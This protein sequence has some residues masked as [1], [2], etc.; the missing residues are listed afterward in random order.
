MSYNTSNMTDVKLQKLVEKR[1]QQ[2]KLLVYN[3]EF[4][5]IIK[6][7]REKY[8][9]PIDG[10]E[11]PEEGLSMLREKVD[12]EELG[13]DMH[14]ILRKFDLPPDWNDAIKYFL[15]LNNISL[16]PTML[17]ITVQTVIPVDGSIPRELSIKIDRF[18]TL[19]DMIDLWPLIET[20]Q[21][22][23]STSELKKQQPTQNLNLYIRA[24]QLRNEGKTSNE[25][26]DILTNETGETIS[27]DD[28]NTYMHRFNQQSARY[29]DTKVG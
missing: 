25:I 10:Y 3:D 13:N 23:L 24:K 12:S 28:V 18:T 19:K 21:Q 6:S 29:Y 16:M 17:G 2:L 5:H 1:E 14:D 11:K 7:L 26:A 9:I 8:S 22:E 20:H 15:V 27:Y 4:Q